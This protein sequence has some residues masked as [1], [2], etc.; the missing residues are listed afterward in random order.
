M[1]RARIPKLM[2]SWFKWAQ[3]NL[4]IHMMWITS[5]GIPCECKLNY[6]LT[7]S[8]GEWEKLWYFSAFVD[9]E[10][11]PVT[12][13]SNL[14]FY[15]EIWTWHNSSGGELSKLEPREKALQRIFNLVALDIRSHIYISDFLLL[16]TRSLYL[17]EWQSDEPSRLS[18]AKLTFSLPAEH[19]KFTISIAGVTLRKQTN[20]NCRSCQWNGFRSSCQWNCNI[21]RE[22]SFELCR[23]CSRR[24]SDEHFTF[25]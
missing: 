10:E 9:W 23:V 8:N 4:F 18:R 5:T 14:L 3:K 22:I 13:E 20:V 1:A 17:P 16:L 25:V 12:L 15:W 7:K 2:V 11:L 24:K 19:T 6:R 21:S